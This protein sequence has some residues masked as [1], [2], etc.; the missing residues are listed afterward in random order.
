MPEDMTLAVRYKEINPPIKIN[1]YF[2][3]PSISIS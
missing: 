1:R 2:K 3:A